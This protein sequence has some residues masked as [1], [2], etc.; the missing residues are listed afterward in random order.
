MCYVTMLSV[1]VFIRYSVMNMKPNWNDTHGGNGMTLTGEMEWHSR[2]KWNDTHGG[3][4]MTLTGE[5]E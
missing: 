1:A 3:N 5:M 4:G 2:G